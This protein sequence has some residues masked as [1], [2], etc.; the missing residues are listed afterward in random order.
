MHWHYQLFTNQEQDYQTDSIAMWTI[1]KRVE[2]WFWLF[3]IFSLLLNACTALAF[4]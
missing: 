4:V 1:R 3:F 2:Y